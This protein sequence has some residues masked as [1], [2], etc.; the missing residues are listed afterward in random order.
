MARTVLQIRTDI[1]AVNAALGELSAGTRIVEFRV[2]SGDSLRMYKYQEITMENLLDLRKI[3]ETELQQ[4]SVTTP[5]F[6]AF[7]NIPMIVTKQGIY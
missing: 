3:L 5:I 4:V 7:G 2:G 1:D 6:R